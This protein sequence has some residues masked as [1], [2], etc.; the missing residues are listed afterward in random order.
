MLNNLFDISH[1]DVMTLIKNEEDRK[2]LKIQQETRQGSIG[3]VDKK[4]AQREKGTPERHERKENYKKMKSDSNEVDEAH[5]DDTDEISS[6]EKVLMS[7]LTT[8]L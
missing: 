5:L 7:N 1:R 4:L 8:M 3:G 2:F 6:S